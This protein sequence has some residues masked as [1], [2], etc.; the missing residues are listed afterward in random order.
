MLKK[1]KTLAVAILLIFSISA[2]SGATEI[3]KPTAH[4]D[5]GGAT[6]SPAN[7]YDFSV[8][9]GNTSANTSAI[10]SDPSITF[11]SFETSTRNYD[12]LA[13]EVTVAS[14]GFTNSDWGVY[15]NNDSSTTCGSGQNVIKPT[16]TENYA[17]T[18]L[19]V[20]L[21]PGQDL[22][23]LEVC[24]SGS[25]KG[26]ENTLIRV[27]DVRTEGSYT[28][29]L[30]VRAQQQNASAVKPGDA[31]E[32]AAQANA[33]ENLSHAV[34]ATNETGAWV[35]Q[36]SY[37]SPVALSG[38]D[39]A[40]ANF[41]W[42]NTYTDRTVGWKIWFNGTSGKYNSTGVKTFRLDSDAPKIKLYS[43][44]NTTLSDTTPP[45]EV[46]ADEETTGWKYNVD[47]GANKSFAPNS[48]LDN[49]VNGFYHLTVWGA[50]LAGNYNTTDVYFT[51]NSS[52]GQSSSSPAGVWSQGG[53]LS[54]SSGNMD[55][56]DGVFLNWS[57]VNRTSS[58]R[59]K[60]L[61][62]NTTVDIPRY[63]IR[64]IEFQWEFKRRV[65]NFVTSIY[66]PGV[67][68]NINYSN[69]NRNAT[70]R[71]DTEFARLTEE[72]QG[73]NYEFVKQGFNFYLPEN[74]SETSFTR[75]EFRAR[76]K[77]VNTDASEA[78]F[79]SFQNRTSGGQYSCGT[80]SGNTYQDFTCS[81]SGSQ[82]N[83][84][85]AADEAQ[86]VFNDTLRSNGEAQSH[87]RIDRM[88]LAAEYEDPAT[89]NTF[90]YE[91][92]YRNRSAGVLENET[93]INVN[94]SLD[95]YSV[96]VGARM[97]EIIS[98]QGE[99][100]GFL[101]FFQ[102]NPMFT[103]HRTLQNFV[104][105]R[106]AVNVNYTLSQVKQYDLA[107][108][109]GTGDPVRGVNVTVFDDGTVIERLTSFGSTLSD[110]LSK[111]HNYTIKQSIPAGSSEYNVTFRNL[112]VTSALSPETQVVN[113]SQQVADVTDL[114]YVYAVN[115]SNTRFG[116]ATLAV[117]KNGAPDVIL[118]CTSWDFGTS[119]CSN[120]EINDTSDYN[121]V[122]TGS[123]IEFNVSGFDAFGTGNGEPLPNVTSI[124]IYDVTN[125]ANKQTEGTLV[126][127]GLNS[128][129]NI[130]Q[131]D[132]ER[133]YR[134]EFK[135]RND[136]NQDWVLENSDELSHS[137]LNSSWSVGQVWY[138]LS[139]RK[140]GG[141]FSSGT[142]TWD[143]NLGG[144]LQNQDGNDTMWAKYLVNI[145]TKQ[146][147]VYDQYF[148]VND[149]SDNAGSTDRH[150]LN[151]TK[152]G[153]LDVVLETPPA[154]VTVQQNKTFVVNASVYCRNGKCGT[155]KVS[156]RYNESSTADTLIPEGSGT[157]FH[158]NN[159]NTNT[160]GTLGKDERCFY[161]WDVNATGPLKS[162]HLVDA[163]AS[164]S[165]SMVP[166]NNSEDSEVTINQAIL[167]DIAWNTV[168]FGVLDPGMTD[169][170][171][172]GNSDLRYN[173]T[174]EENSLTVDNLWVRGEDLVTDGW[175][176]PSTG[177]NYSIPVQ[178]ISYS[179]VNDISTETSLLGKYQ[180][181]GTSIQPGTN[182]TTF[183]WIDVPLGIK[184]STYEGN[185][186]FKANGTS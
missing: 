116:K 126:A 9:N 165:Y 24:F 163:N 114:S 174:I 115:T 80:Y 184:T 49:L 125:T 62:V 139:N 127:S 38:T 18:N 144:T 148:E 122:D 142:V 112:N 136:G 123:H 3:R 70:Y 8:Y 43:P 1:R 91:L 178:N 11:S 97:E 14:S 75:L 175:K 150:K 7:A 152:Y 146:S 55:S 41:T 56:T 57:D 66:D 171:A 180:R 108:T 36:T 185:I 154:T 99:V 30:K 93:T 35:N 6:T 100:T 71:Q 130:D 68:G 135:I 106:F 83:D 182:H 5:P 133:E 13:L 176:N 19:S 109:N 186:Y 158:T 141:T 90:E 37:G 21:P 121:A 179:S 113:Y 78:L 84:I 16:G 181:I 169:Q 95:M 177:S 52:Y 53:V 73:Q 44:S 131:Q 27:F 51:V 65:D 138:N 92:G 143:T 29:P 50:D 129:L 77:G 101:S 104:I 102:K 17:K 167:I 85:V 33:P 72:A 22:S 64:D 107:V 98:K 86:V 28:V 58:R 173:I 117:P 15:Y 88:S 23:L 118:H 4:T 79:V 159:T 89:G 120:W 31:I 63:S 96:N 132:R 105:D 69:S 59:Q 67:N 140:I 76:L 134:V 161:A 45:I 164:S 156:T 162:V 39:W 155:V 81:V 47:D 110:Q 34:L 119:T 151:I 12:A 160:C 48:S 82:V 54:G 137:G 172:S 42:S 168:D 170:P 25:N 124:E 103:S 147:R 111:N 94:G 32:L 60:L 74:E 183:Y 2:V 40:W 26:N 87:W 61:M 157:P 128:T 46:A 10:S 149:T 20:S 166:A 145:S 153:F